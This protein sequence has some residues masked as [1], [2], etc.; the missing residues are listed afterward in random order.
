[1]RAAEARALTST[2]IAEVAPSTQPAT[3]VVQ[4][5]GR[6]VGFVTKVADG[7]LAGTVSGS[8]VCRGVSRRHAAVR[9]LLM[10]YDYHDLLD[11]GGPPDD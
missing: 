8:E 5:E 7:W 10:H 3:F 11:P 9:R 6:P 4:V 1:M 2:G